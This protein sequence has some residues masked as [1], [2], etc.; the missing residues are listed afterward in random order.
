M[1]TEV[2]KDDVRTY[3]GPTIWGS[4]KYSVTPEEITTGINM[5]AS[6]RSASETTFNLLGQKVNSNAKGI[7]VK[8]GK[9]F[10]VR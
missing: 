2:V 5:V 4:T 9:K 1:P 3:A 6:N 8:G 10:V 7:L